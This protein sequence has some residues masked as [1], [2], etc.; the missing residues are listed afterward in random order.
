M[1][2]EV[3]F[4]LFSIIKTAHEMDFKDLGGDHALIL[5]E[6]KHD[7]QHGE[8]AI[9]CGGRGFGSLI[10]IL[11]KAMLEDEKLMNILCLAVASALAEKD[12]RRNGKKK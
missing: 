7:E 10:N 11:V 2:L 3:K 5:V 9:L 6:A 4:D 1:G 8:I 12:S